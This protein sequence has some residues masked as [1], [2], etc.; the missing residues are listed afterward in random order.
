MT[1][2]SHSSLTPISRADLTSDLTSDRTPGRISQLVNAPQVQDH[3]LHLQHVRASQ[4][5]TSLMP[6]RWAVP[7]E[8]EAL[9]AAVAQQLSGC[10]SSALPGYGPPPSSCP[11][12]DPRRQQGQEEVQDANPVV[13]APRP[14]PTMATCVSLGE[15][16]GSGW[17]RDDVSQARVP[18]TA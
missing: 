14:L 10:G 17:G 11:H 3:T 13:G 6:G 15:I 2:P 1:L 18:V 4:L 9:Q 16:R 12:H 5:C 8:L 7:Q